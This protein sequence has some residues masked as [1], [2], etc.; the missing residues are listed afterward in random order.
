MRYDA[1]N[2]LVEMVAGPLTDMTTWDAPPRTVTNCAT[3][4]LN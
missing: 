4:D 1:S 3:V 2:R